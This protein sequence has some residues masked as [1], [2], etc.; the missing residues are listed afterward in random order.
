MTSPTAE[1]IAKTTWERLN[2][3]YD[4]GSDLT[5][6]EERYCI[7]IITEAIKQAPRAEFPSW[8]ALETEFAEVNGD[9]RKLYDWLRSRIE[10]K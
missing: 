9:L 3:V 5:V 2:E 4:L 6:S 8:D 1:E 7:F 10:A